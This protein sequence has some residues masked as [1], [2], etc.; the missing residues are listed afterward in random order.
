[1]SAGAPL[2]LAAIEGA[3][4]AIAERLRRIT[5]RLADGHGA[6]GSG[7][8]WRADG[9]IV[10]NAHVARGD[11]IDA[12]L[13]DG[14]EVIG[15]VVARSRGLDLALIEIPL[16]TVDVA[17][18]AAAASLAPGALVFAM[19]SP[20]GIPD[21]LAIGIAHGTM[22]T[23]RRGRPVLIGADI[24]LAPGNSGGPL[25]NAAGHV[26]GINSMVVN[27]LGIAVASDTVE[28]FVQGAKVRAAA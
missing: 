13:P 7:V 9:M 6:A 2:T 27:G 10:T 19:G 8:L 22:R 16:R 1:M 21:A 4:A 12:Y 11:R 14:R 17:T 3:T 20:H 23:D 18:F 26:V 24:R 5:V 28:A 15:R 25:A